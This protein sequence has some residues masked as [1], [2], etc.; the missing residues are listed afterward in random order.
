MLVSF[1]S[2]R[3]FYD[4]TYTIRHGLAAG[5]RRKGGL[6]FLPF[7]PAETPEFGFLRKLPIEG[8]VIYD[9]GAFEG[10]LTLFFARRATQ[11]VAFEPNPRN[12][13]RC[14]ENIR[15]NDL[16]N[17]KI[18]NRGVADHAGTI[19]LIYDPLMPGAGTGDMA[20]RQQIA[21]S[22]KTAHKVRIDVISLDDDIP[23][24]GLPLPDLIKIDVE[25][26]ELAALKGMQR[27]LRE[28]RPELFIELHGA[29]RKQKAENSR[30]VVDFLESCRY[31]LYDVENDSYITAANLGDR[32]PSHLY[33]TS[34]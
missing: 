32:R 25:G 11:V 13:I 7:G 18:L 1:I 21:S 28:R 12:Y 34:L 17:V 6:G 14:L 31:Q 5:M 33:C 24:N 2:Q 16:K 30:A 19:E 3:F 15:L 29:T 8:K 26:M 4:R 23:V 22:T 20:T 9:I 27:T 10:L